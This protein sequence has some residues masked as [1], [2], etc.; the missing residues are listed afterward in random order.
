VP[1]EEAPAPISVLISSEETP[2]GSGGTVTLPVGAS[3]GTNE[4]DGA[5]DPID[6]GGIFALSTGDAISVASP[7]SSNDGTWDSLQYASP[8]GLCFCRCLCFCLCLCLC[9][10]LSIS[11]CICDFVTVFVSL[12]LSFVSFSLYV[13]K[14]RI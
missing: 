3:H 12:L 2:G 1:V 8:S 13:L 11:R 5:E 7:A 14:K 9:R 10:C 4:G 6:V